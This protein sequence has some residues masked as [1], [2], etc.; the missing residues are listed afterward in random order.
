MSP[1]SSKDDGMYKFMDSY[2]KWDESPNTAGVDDMESSHK[3][4]ADYSS[5]STN[6]SIKSD[7]WIGER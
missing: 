5:D 7:F 4:T 2:D 6:E 3:F 1:D